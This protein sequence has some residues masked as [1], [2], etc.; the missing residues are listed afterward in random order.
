MRLSNL[1]EQASGV[2]VR[3]GRLGDLNV[4][5][6]STE[7]V[8]EKTIAKSSHLGCDFD[9]NGDCLLVVPP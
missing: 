9:G 2:R 7:R 4:L 5:E 8:N 3:S 1:L 6:I